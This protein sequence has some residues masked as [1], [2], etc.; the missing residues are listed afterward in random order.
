MET[1]Q[2]VRRLE[3]LTWEMGKSRY[4][5]DC[6]LRCSEM[7]RS[8]VGD[9]TFTFTLEGSHPIT[10][11]NEESGLSVN[12]LDTTPTPTLDPL[13]ATQSTIYIHPLSDLHSNC[14]VFLLRCAHLLF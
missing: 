6:V 11:E 8:S 2:G 7:N 9:G 4:E 14:C 3:L 10:E 5:L 1:R 12:I 13:T